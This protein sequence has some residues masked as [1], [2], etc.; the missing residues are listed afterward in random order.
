MARKLPQGEAYIFFKKAPAVTK[1]VF[2]AERCHARH[3]RRILGGKLADKFIP[4]V[5]ADE[6]PPD[7]MPPLDWF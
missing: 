2:N 7:E 1:L 3:F 5:T 6:V 4:E